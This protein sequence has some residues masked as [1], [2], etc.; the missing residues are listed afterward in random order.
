MNVVNYPWGKD[1]TSNAGEGCDVCVL[2]RTRPAPNTLLAMAKAG[3]NYMNSQLIKMEALV[4]GFAEGIAL[5]DRG[6]VSEGS[7]ENIFVVSGGVVNTPPLS[8]SVLPGITRDSVITLL[9][10]MGY[11]V[12]EEPV[13]IENVVR[14]HRRGQLRECFG[15]G[16]AATVTHVGRIRYRDEIIELPQVDERTV[17]PLAREK[18]LGVMTGCQPDPHGWVEMI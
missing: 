17:G 5:D 4:N 8:S 1:L 10:D 11:T 9:R 15:T 14:L 2:S 7:G 16:T 6:Y 3:A 13:A 12:R 18:L